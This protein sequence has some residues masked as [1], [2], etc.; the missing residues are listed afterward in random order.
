MYAG[1]KSKGEYLIENLPQVS[2]FDRI[3]FIDDLEV[4]LNSVINS[5]KKSNISVPVLTYKYSISYK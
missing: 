5:I 1:S 4:N 3:I 2:S